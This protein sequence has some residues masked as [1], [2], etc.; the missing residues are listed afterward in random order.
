MERLKLACQRIKALFTRHTIEREI[1]DEMRLHVDLLA[2]EYEKSGATADEAKRL[3]LRRFGNIGR[4][5]ERSRDVRGGGVLDDVIRDLHYAIRM[6]RRS[7]LFTVVVVMSLALGIGAITALFTVIDAAFLRKLAVDKPDELVFFRWTSGPS[8]RPFEPRNTVGN[9]MRW[10]PGAAD[11]SAP[12]FSSSHHFRL[13]PLKSFAP[14]GKVFRTYSRSLHSMPA[15]GLGN[16]RSPRWG[17]LFPVI[18]SQRLAFAL[19]QSE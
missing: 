9:F 3:A 17:N 10:G 14:V 13:L 2:E 11:G 4:V 15:S 12:G 16:R 7:P 5:K 18:I 6:L 1:D 19:K 8:L